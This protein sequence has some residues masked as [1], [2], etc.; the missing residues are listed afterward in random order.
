MAF[1]LAPQ[2]NISLLTLSLQH[3]TII[4]TTPLT[5]ALSWCPWLGGRG[6]ASCSPGRGRGSST[7]SLSPATPPPPAWPGPAAPHPTRG[8]AHWRRI[9]G[10]QPALYFL[11]QKR[12][13]DQPEVISE[14]IVLLSF[15]RQRTLG[16]TIYTW[17]LP[18][19]ARGVIEIINF[20]ILL[21]ILLIHIYLYR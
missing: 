19:G 7:R 4:M 11:Q 1:S 9:E 2:E 20:K 3:F 8:K 18:A 17:Q 21:N 14:Q 15:T 16:N 6:S 5:W 13:S 12:N 10:C